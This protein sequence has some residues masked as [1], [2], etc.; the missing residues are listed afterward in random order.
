MLPS[1]GSLRGTPAPLAGSAP[2]SER[3]SLRRPRGPGPPR[4]SGPV[5]WS[6]GHFSV[7][8]AA[9]APCKSRAAASWPLLC[10][11]SFICPEGLAPSTAW[12]RAGRRDGES[13]WSWRLLGS[14]RGAGAVVCGW[15]L[16]GLRVGPVSGASLQA[17]QLLRPE[18]VVVRWQKPWDAEA[19]EAA[20]WSSRLEGRGKRELERRPRRAQEWDGEEEGAQS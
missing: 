11:P 5:L 6:P 12:D 19:R 9:G 13:S 18:R 7:Q 8:A 10:M 16:E 20:A 4:K 3:R 1:A 2:E 14:W 17:Q 15:L